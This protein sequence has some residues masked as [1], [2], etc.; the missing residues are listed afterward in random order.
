MHT[1]NSF[2]AQTDYKLIREQF[3]RAIKHDTESYPTVNHNSRVKLIP[4]GD[5]DTVR[6]V[7]MGFS[8]VDTR[9]NVFVKTRNNQSQPTIAL[10][11]IN[12]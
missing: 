8:R 6:V 3:C 7:T 9:S 12:Y 4:Q 11:L 5:I 1:T 10:E 2:P